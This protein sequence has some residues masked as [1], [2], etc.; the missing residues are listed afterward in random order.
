MSESIKTIECKATANVVV[1]DEKQAFEI[2]FDLPVGDTLADLVSLYGEEIVA[3]YAIAN[4]KVRAQALMRSKVI[5]HFEGKESGVPPKQIAEYMA[6]WKPDS[7][8]VTRK[9][10]KTKVL[11]ALSNLSEEQQKALLEQLRA[12][13]DAQTATA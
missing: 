3:Q 11:K 10:P 5:Q 6:T 7:Q 4:M 12:Q 9:D 8:P 1:N 2:S 13:L